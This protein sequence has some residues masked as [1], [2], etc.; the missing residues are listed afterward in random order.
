MKENKE[1][2]IKN[3]HSFSL[4]VVSALEE[5]EK[6]L[7]GE[8]EGVSYLDNMLIIN[9]NGKTPSFVYSIRDNWFF[10][11]KD[12]PECLKFRHNVDTYFKKIGDYWANDPQ[13]Y[14]KGLKLHTSNKYWL[15]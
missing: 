11:K 2:K 3:N 9:P 12:L 15:H 6:Y 8:K 10:D 1:Y 5:D 4:Y 13:D 14:S 7:L